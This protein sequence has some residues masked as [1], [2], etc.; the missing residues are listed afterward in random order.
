MR[1][2]KR[3][4][5]KVLLVFDRVYYTYPLYAVYAEVASVAL[6][7]ELHVQTV[8]SL[9]HELEVTD[10]GLWI[11]VSTERAFIEF[12]TWRAP[13]F[14][15]RVLR[16]IIQAL[17]RHGY[18]LR[19]VELKTRIVIKFPDSHRTDSQHQTQRA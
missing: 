19:E 16:P 3:E 11:R 6:V 13:Q 7:N 4:L 18:R 2:V 1:T 5:V 14:R 15:E 8:E 10:I 9:K 17:L 12:D